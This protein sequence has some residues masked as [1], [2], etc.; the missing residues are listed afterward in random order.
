[1]TL[2]TT[3][4]A[5]TSSIVVK[6]SRNKGNLQGDS[7]VFR[8]YFPMPFADMSIGP[9]QSSED[10]HGNPPKEKKKDDIERE[11]IK[12]GE[13]QSKKRRGK[14]DKT[15]KIKKRKSQS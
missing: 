9:S 14:N 7:G 15:R 6:I 11:E 10:G 4:R 13:R 3:G 12:R 8:M 2:R 1:M 5:K